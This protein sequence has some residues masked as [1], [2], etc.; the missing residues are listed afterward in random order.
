[1]LEFGYRAPK[2]E[3]NPLFAIALP[4]KQSIAKIAKSVNGK[5]F[6]VCPG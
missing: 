1:V 2:S 3:K 4:E 6:S 5:D